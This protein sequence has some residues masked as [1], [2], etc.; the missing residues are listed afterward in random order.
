MR[1][2]RRFLGLGVKA[3]ERCWRSEQSLR[4]LAGLSLYQYQACP[5][6]I[7]VRRAM[8]L[9]GIAVELRDIDSESRFNN[10]LIQQGGVR[11]V[12]CLRIGTEQPERWLYESDAIIAY[13]RNQTLTT[14]PTQ[15]SSSAP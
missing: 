13:L 8:R 11:Q 5:F 12:P 4:P 1:L 2:I 15:S 7:K 3:V 6:C 14:T 9:Q 10:E